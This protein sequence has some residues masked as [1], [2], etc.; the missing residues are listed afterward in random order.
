M[1]RAPHPHLH[2]PLT[3]SNMCSQSSA[4][5]HTTKFMKHIIDANTTS[6]YIRISL[7]SF[8]G[9]SPS[10]PKQF[11]QDMFLYP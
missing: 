5:H 7:F 8:P 3:T 4:Q 2:L 9:S 6:Q 10:D 1:E 11:T